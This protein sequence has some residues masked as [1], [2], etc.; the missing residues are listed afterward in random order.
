MQIMQR[1]RAMGYETT[2]LSMGRQ[3]MASQSS[4]NFNEREILEVVSLLLASALTG[5]QLTSF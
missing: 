4:D 1:M 3:L 5:P 2:N